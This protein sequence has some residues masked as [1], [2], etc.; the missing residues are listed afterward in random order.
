MD[1]WTQVG[2]FMAAGVLLMGFPILVISFFQAGFFGKWFKARSSRGR[3]V[4]VKIR[5]KLRD[6]F[7]TGEIQ[8]EFLVWGKK[9]HTKRL[10]LPENSVYRSW[11]LAV[12]DIDEASNG[13]CS[14][15]YKPISGFDAEKHEG[16]YIR[17]LYRP[18]LDEEMSKFEKIMIILVIVSIIASVA[19]IF[20][21]FQLSEQ[22]AAIGGGA[23][24]NVV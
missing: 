23:I 22:I 19:A 7:D 5:G 8:G 15:S 18:S 12:V 1:F 3:L 16:L 10:L 24:N 2:Y 14:V 13:V 4:L 17:A 21:Q 20:L 9:E 11:G 6:Y